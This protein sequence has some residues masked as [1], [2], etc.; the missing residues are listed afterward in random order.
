MKRAITTIPDDAWTTINQFNAIRDYATGTWI[1][2]AKVA[3]IPFTA[4]SSRK[5][6]ERITGRRAV[7][8]IPELN[9]FESDG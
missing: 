8:R 2:S 4:F 6:S 7:R 3:E 5:I 9:A 1:S